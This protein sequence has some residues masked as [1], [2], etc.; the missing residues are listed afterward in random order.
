MLYSG[1]DP[2]SYITECT[3]VYQGKKGQSQVQI[4]DLARD[5]YSRSHIETLIIYKLSSSKFTTK[6]AVYEKY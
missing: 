2:E 3:L 1:T 6:N 5:L 4:P